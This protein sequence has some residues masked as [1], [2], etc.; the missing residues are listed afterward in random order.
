MVRYLEV[1]KKYTWN[2]GV[3]IKC[4]AIDVDGNAIGLFVDSR[5]DYMDGDFWD[6]YVEPKIDVVKKIVTR[7]P[8]GY[9][10]CIGQGVGQLEV[11]GEV[12]ITIRDGKVYSVH[13]L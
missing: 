3:P 4:V 5:L 1:G 6:E 12:E 9:V 11:L 8:S 10:A 13:V 2:G 7:D